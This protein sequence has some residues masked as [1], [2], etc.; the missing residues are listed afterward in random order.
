MVKYDE[1]RPYWVINE[2]KDGKKVY[3]CDR[4]LKSIHLVNTAPI[5]DVLKVIESEED[6]RYAYWSEEEV[7]EDLPEVAETESEDG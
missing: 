6:G 4:K 1:V 2:I 7:N 3:V 5:A